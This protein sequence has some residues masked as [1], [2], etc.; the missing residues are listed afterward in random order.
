[1]DRLQIHAVITGDIDLVDGHPN[2]IAECCSSLGLKTIFPLWGE[3]RA[4]HM[5]ERMARQIEARISWINHGAI[6]VEWI[7]RVIDDVLVKE[8]TAL[9]ESKGIDL[10]GENGE[11]H[12][13]VSEFS[14]LPREN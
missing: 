12:T 5:R 6:P 1:M 13:M 9:S 3:S 2:W 10:C 4:N 14:P 11:Y 7:G 8:L